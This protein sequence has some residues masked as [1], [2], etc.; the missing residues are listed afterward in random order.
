MREFLGRG[1][2]VL[3][4]FFAFTLGTTIDA[5]SVWHA[6][7][8][9]VALGLFVV[10]FTGGVLWVADRLSG[11]T[12]VAGVA[13]ASTAGNAAAVPAIVAAANPAY[14]DAARSAT[15]LVS[16]SVVVTAVVVPFLT[17]WLARRKAGADAQPDRSAVRTA[18]QLVPESRR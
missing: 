1:V 16:A 10:A 13:A 5:R 9:G 6:G 8:L 2:P 4:P 15:V 18:T 7:L 17:A 11:G 3:I 12:G 14:A